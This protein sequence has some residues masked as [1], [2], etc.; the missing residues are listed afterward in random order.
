MNLISN[1]K[2]LFI[3]TVFTQLFTS[4]EDVVDI[5]TDPLTPQ[6]VVDAW[7]N[8]RSEPQTIS[9]S[10]TQ[11]YFQNSLPEG[12][13][14]ATVKVIRGD[15]EVFEFTETENGQY[16]WTPSDDETL[17]IVNDEFNLSIELDGKTYE[18]ASTMNRTPVIDSITQEFRV[19]EFGFPD[20]IYAEFF[21]RDFVGEGDTYWIKTFKN[22]VFLNK[23]SEINFAF[24]A[25][26]SQG[27][28]VDGLIFIPPIREA[29]NRTA[30][31]D[32]D[33]NSDVAPWN[34]EDEIRVEI[35]SINHD[36]FYFLSTAQ[37][38]MLNGQNGIFSEPVIN[39]PGNIFSVNDEEEVLGVFNVA[40]ISEL[41]KVVE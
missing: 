27:A 34:L 6:L 3:L 41:T 32:T 5:K 33:D 28:A 25:G 9:L 1:I 18:S 8:N 26:F 40:A 20:G 2:Y 24:D 11:P 13:G 7:L 17:G 35:H 37:R 12:I 38:Q 30:D 39:T 10:M 21:A 16:N 36:A 23:P 29:I 14:G 19:D 22:G 31:A 15:N 4:C